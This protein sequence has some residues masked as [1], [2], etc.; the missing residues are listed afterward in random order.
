MRE[1]RKIKQRELFIF[2]LWFIG[3]EALDSLLSME[4][5]SSGFKVHPES[6]EMMRGVTDHDSM[7]SISQDSCISDCASGNLIHMFLTFFSRFN[8]FMDKDKDV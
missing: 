3:T 8:S 7:N 5:T 2:N 4:Q 6:V 1:I